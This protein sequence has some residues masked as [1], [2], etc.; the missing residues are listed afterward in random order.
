MTW[1]CG[2]RWGA[3]HVLGSVRR[4][5]RAVLLPML[6]DKERGRVKA[7]CVVPG[8]TTGRVHIFARFSQPGGNRARGCFTTARRARGATGPQVQG[9]RQ[10]GVG[11]RGGGANMLPGVLAQQRH[12]LILLAGHLI[13]KRA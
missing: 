9:E 6:P 3:H 10:T 4:T 2:G 11:R 5:G 13:T 12:P 7:H 8:G 1:L